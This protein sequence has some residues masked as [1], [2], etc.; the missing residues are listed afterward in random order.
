M[1]CSTPVFPVL[2]YLLEFVRIHVHW[3]GDAISSSAA[4]PLLP[5]VF[6]STGSF[7]LSW[8]FASGGQ[9]IGA[10]ASA[11]VLPINIQSWFPLGLTYLISLLSKR[12]SESSLAPQFKSIN[13]SAL[14]V[15]GPLSHPYITTGKAIALT[16]QTFVGKVM[17]LLFNIMSHLGKLIEF[18]E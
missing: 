4:H 1:D 2:H 3:V 14:S 16:I 13:S 9:S 7:P 18:K 11:L 5:S 6:P 10:S 15:Y 8:L 17:Y 12:L